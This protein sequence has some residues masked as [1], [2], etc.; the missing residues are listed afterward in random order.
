MIVVSIKSFVCN[1]LLFF[2]IILWESVIGFHAVLCTGL[3]AA[4]SFILLTNS[5]SYTL[6]FLWPFY[7]NSQRSPREAAAVGVT[8]Y[9]VLVDLFVFVLFHFWEHYQKHSFPNPTVGFH[10]CNSNTAEFSST[11]DG[12]LTHIYFHQLFYRLQYKIAMNTII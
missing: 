4:I 7:N 2:V 1:I 11:D 8:W 10:Q 12:D 9:S 3:T 5:H 6:H